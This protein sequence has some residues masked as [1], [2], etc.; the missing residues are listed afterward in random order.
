MKM[1]IY[2]YKYTLITYNDNKYSKYNIWYKYK[3]EEWKLLIAFILK[4]IYL[5]FEGWKYACTQGFNKCMILKT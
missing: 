1:K 2:I 4:Y 5:Q 3:M